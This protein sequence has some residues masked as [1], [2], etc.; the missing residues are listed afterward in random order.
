MPDQIRE[1]QH[2]AVE[3]RDDN[4]FAPAKV[5]LDFARQRFDAPGNLLVGD[6]DFLHL[7]APARR[8]G[9]FGFC[10]FRFELGVH[11]KLFQRPAAVR[12]NAGVYLT[13]EPLGFEERPDDA[14][15]FFPL[16]V[17]ERATDAVF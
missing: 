12:L 3:Q 11:K 16:V 4:H 2:R 15:I 1:E 10:D 14:L 17:A 5:A 8:D 6:E 9:S 13:H 7:L